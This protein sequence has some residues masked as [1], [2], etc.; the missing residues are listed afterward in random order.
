MGRAQCVCS[1]GPSMLGQAAE[2]LL[3]LCGAYFQRTVWEAGSGSQGGR[4]QDRSS[5]VCRREGRCG[6]S[7]RPVLGR[8]DVTNTAPSLVGRWATLISSWTR[9]AKADSRPE[10]APALA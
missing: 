7:C 6:L 4:G 1:P 8:R 9:S 10:D 2:D 3:R 5:V